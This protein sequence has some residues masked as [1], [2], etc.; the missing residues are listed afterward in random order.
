MNENK[1]G[2]IGSSPDV[3]TSSCSCCGRLLIGNEIK[4]QLHVVCG[5][6]GWHICVHPDPQNSYDIEEKRAILAGRLQE[7]VRN[8]V[9]RKGTLTSGGIGG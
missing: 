9:G 3:E 5:T 6:C 8:H 7:H 2:C 1:E 4:V